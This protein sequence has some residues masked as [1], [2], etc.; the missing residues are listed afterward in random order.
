MQVRFGG[1]APSFT[2]SDHSSSRGGGAWWILLATSYGCQGESRVP[3]YTHGLT[4]A[5]RFS[6]RVIHQTSNPCF[7]LY[8]AFSEAASNIRQALLN[9]GGAAAAYGPL[10]VAAAVRE[11]LRDARRCWR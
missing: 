6:R 10:G 5:F 7:L 8:T 11:A 4:E 2:S 9:I 3:H 1:A